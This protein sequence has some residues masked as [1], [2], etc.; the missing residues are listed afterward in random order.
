MET[1][2]GSQCKAGRRSTRGERKDHSD[3]WCSRAGGASAKLAPGIYSE[4]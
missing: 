1:V 4:Q 3:I 2:I